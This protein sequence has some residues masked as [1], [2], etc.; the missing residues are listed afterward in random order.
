MKSVNCFI[1]RACTQKN[2]L[3]ICLHLSYSRGLLR[4][5]QQRL[6]VLQ[7]CPSSQGS[8][9]PLRFRKLL[10][11]SLVSFWQQGGFVTPGSQSLAFPTKPDLL[12]TYRLKVNLQQ[13]IH[14]QCVLRD[15]FPQH[16]E[17]I[18]RIDRA[19]LSQG[20]YCCAVGQWSSILSIVLL[21]IKCL[22]YRSQV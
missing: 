14:Y 9:W 17:Y 5:G 21:L 4:Q 6:S 8:V 16:G 7:T 15:S 12:M 19:C 11:S 18:C 2:I 1:Q 20:H 10:L 22:L 13:M 3:M